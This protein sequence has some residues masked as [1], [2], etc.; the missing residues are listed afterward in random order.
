MEET[1]NGAIRHFDEVVIVEQTHVQVQVRSDAPPTYAEVE[2]EDIRNGRDLP[3]YAEATGLR[4]E[5]PP[6]Y[7]EVEAEDIRRRQSVVRQPA[8]QSYD[9]DSVVTDANRAEYYSNINNSVR[10]KVARLQRQNVQLENK[11]D[12][13]KTIGD[14]I[15]HSHMAKV[16]K[17]QALT[18]SNYKLER[19]LITIER[20]THEAKQKCQQDIRE[21]TRNNK[22]ELENL[23]NQRNESHQRE[24]E[25]FKQRIENMRKELEKKASKNGKY[26]IDLA[27]PLVKDIERLRK[28]ISKI[29]KQCEVEF[30]YEM[31]DLWIL[32]RDFYKSRPNQRPC[33]LNVF[34]QQCEKNMQWHN[35]QLSREGNEE[36]CPESCRDEDLMKRWDT[37]IYPYFEYYRSELTDKLCQALELIRL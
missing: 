1:Q 26:F 28:A 20:K 27:Q 15:E 17:V 18:E 31:K 4:R 22:T 35:D 33:V 5:E 6:T 29:Y 25:A 30:R 23:I 36:P 11:A 3:T 24:C 34:K 7:A 14:R 8:E 32:A 2:A 10:D 12:E 21:M 9:Y 37:V 16:R 19:T 13:L